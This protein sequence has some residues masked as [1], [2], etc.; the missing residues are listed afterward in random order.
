M[1]T[2]PTYAAAARTRALVAASSAGA[3]TTNPARQQASP[4]S[5]TLICDGPSSPIEIPLCV[6]T[7]FR[8]TKG[9]A[10]HTRSCSKPLFIANAEKLETNGPLPLGHHRVD[11]A[12]GLEPA[13]QV[14]ESRAL[15]GELS[16]N[17]KCIRETES[18]CRRLRAD[19]KSV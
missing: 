4:I 16:Q 3:I 14:Y 5:S 2:G 11:L 8:F 12:A 18:N 15:P 9:Y 17:R 19:R 1:N 7:T 6:P 13:S 10:A